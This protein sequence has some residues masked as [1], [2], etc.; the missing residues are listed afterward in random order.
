MVSLWGFG[1]KASGSQVAVSTPDTRHSGQMTMTDVLERYD[2]VSV[3]EMA[4]S[5]IVT[6]K[7][8]KQFV[9]KVSDVPIGEIG[10]SSPSPFTSF[11]R[12]EY[13]NKLRGLQGLQTYDKMRRGDG[14]VRSSLRMLRTPVLAAEWFVQ[15]ASDSKR[16]QNV[17][18]FIW[19]NLNCWMS[20]AWGQVLFESTLMLDFGYYMFEKVFW[21]QEPRAKGM[22]SWKKLAPRHPMDVEQWHFD[23][24]GGP[25]SVDFYPW[26]QFEFVDKNIKI[27]KLLVM[28][29]DKE[30]GNIQGISALRSAYKHWFYKDNLLKI[31]A[32]Q[33][34]RHGIGVPIIKLPP[35]FTDADRKLAEEMGRNLRT[36]ER[37]HIILPP[38]WDI[39][40]AKLEGQHV[41]ALASVNLHN[42]ELWGNILG[43]FMN[44]GDKQQ[45]A[46]ISD[47]QVFFLKAS[48]Y[49]AGIV[50]DTFN[51]HAIPQ[52]VDYN[53]MRLN[54]YPELKARSIAEQVDTRT[55]SFAL[56]NLVGSGL[57]TPD[58]Q[59]EDVLRNIMDLPNFDE[60]TA[61]MVPTP[62]ANPDDE[63]VGPDG[64]P[65]PPGSANPPVPGAPKP[66][67]PARVG[68]P[69]QSPKAGVGLPRPNAGR[70]AS[71][72][73]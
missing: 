28:S 4:Q 8:G 70:D 2:I 6:E 58:G 60:A 42:Q 71:G 37:A 65:I 49:V 25:A 17:A 72:G 35:N 22:V 39:M 36:N 34:E 12:M 40:F 53:W 48:Q 27:D 14:T 44:P 47:L 3:D 59:L 5:V 68:P 38:N 16:D 29:Y 41:D 55:L 32:I 61:R 10:S 30:A 66:P 18:E 31:D 51:K 56:R 19:N 45:G 21:D 9:G 43:G 62:Q 1:K 54:G 67:A 11:T 73:K 20:N 26:D 7:P 33:K 15:P 64:K 63:E 13:N 52:L 50:R 23:T 69:R 24:N 57:I 46:A